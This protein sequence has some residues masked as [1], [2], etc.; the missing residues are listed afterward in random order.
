MLPT[1]IFQQAFQRVVTI[2]AARRARTDKI[3]WVG[4]SN[5]ASGPYRASERARLLALAAE[6][7]VK[8][9]SGRPSSSTTPKPP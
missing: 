8:V 9:L 6:S 1:V 4:G 5:P 7:R 2:A 3:K